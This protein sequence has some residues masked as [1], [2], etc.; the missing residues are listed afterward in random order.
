MTYLMVDNN[1]IENEHLCCAISDKKHQDGVVN[2]KVWLSDQFKKGHRF[3]K[4]NQNAKVFIEYVPL[5]Q[6]WVPVVGENYLYIHCL[7]VSGSFKENGHASH[8]INKCISDAKAMGKSGICVISSKKKK[9]FLTE[10]SF[11]KKYGFEVVATYQ[12]EY[13]LLALSFDGTIPTFSKSLLSSDD[14]ISEGI[15]IYYSNQC[16]YTLNCVN[17]SKQWLEEKG[18]KYEVIH[19]SSLEMAKALPVLFN[20]W[21]VVINGKFK[22]LHLLN[23][24]YLEKLLTRK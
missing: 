21:A 18:L 22:T 5:E 10:Y 3:Y 15:T 13:L 4:L 1:N 23:R 24:T 16:P 14:R 12:D 11:Y 17:E 20:N 6:A 7:W 8:L 2:K 19:V 9:P